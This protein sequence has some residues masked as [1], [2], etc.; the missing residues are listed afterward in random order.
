MSRIIKTK[1]PKEIKIHAWGHVKWPVTKWRNVLWS[2][3]TKINLFGSDSLLKYIRRPEGKQ[4]DPRYMIKTVKH[5]G[6]NIT[7]WV[8]FYYSSVGP[9]QETMT[10]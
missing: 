8:C 10:E 3:E 6:G 1:C 2:D 5:G 9:I 4:F 7:V